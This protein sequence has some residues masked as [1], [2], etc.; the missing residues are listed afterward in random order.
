[1]FDLLKLLEFFRELFLRL[2][3]ELLVSP[4]DENQLLKLSL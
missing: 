3:C 2:W 4:S 1:M